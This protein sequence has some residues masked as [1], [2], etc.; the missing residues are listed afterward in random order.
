MSL[1]VRTHAASLNIVKVLKRNDSVF[2]YYCQTLEVEDVILCVDMFNM[3]DAR[4][5]LALKSTVRSS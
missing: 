4:Q 1:G 3:Y 2:V 5:P